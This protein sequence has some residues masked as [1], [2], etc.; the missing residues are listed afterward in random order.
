M[1]PC[2]SYEQFR[3]AVRQNGWTREQ[4]RCDVPPCKGILEVISILG[5]DVYER[6]VTR[7]CR[8]ND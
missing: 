3:A 4:I 5:P 6:Y 2:V 1:M 7:Y 8:E